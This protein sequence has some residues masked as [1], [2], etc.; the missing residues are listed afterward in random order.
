MGTDRT[1]ALWPSLAPLLGAGSF[2]DENPATRWTTFFASG[3]A[4]ADALSDEIT[5]VKT[6]RMT[7]L[8]AAGYDAASPPK[9]E[10]FDKP[11]AAFG[12]GH[13]KL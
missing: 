7:A 12:A 3:S 13:K 4:W 5:R 6:L 9:S 10:L 2:K 1:P 8:A 11:H